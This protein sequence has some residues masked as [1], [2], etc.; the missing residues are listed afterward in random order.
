M[1]ERDATPEDVVSYWREAG[2]QQWFGKDPAFDAAFRERFLALHE[3]AARGDLD[4]W[5][6]TAEGTL[7]LVIL[8]DQFPRNAFRGTPR[9]YA[10][11]ARARTVAARA[12][13]TMLDAEVPAALRFFIYLPFAHSESLADQERSVRLHGALGD[14]SHA[15][16]HRDIVRRFG[17]FP[18]R[19]EI[20][21]RETTAEERAFLDGGGFSG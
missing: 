8:L 6:V 15:E 19:N 18:H 11:D 5:A 21:G 20:L 9:M 16:G 4:R 7:A 1:S 13:D 17:R 2:E 12:V 14:T 3:A 10:T